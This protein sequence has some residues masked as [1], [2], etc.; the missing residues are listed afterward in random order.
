M[1]SITPID[2]RTLVRLLTEQLAPSTA[3]HVHG[4]L[5]TGPALGGRRRLPGQEP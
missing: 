2:V 3:H 1:A 5:A 4:L